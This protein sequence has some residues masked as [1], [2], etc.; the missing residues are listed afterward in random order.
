[1]P[2]IAALNVGIFPPEAAFASPGGPVRV[3]STAAHAIRAGRGP[4]HPAIRLAAAP[5]TERGSW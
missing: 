5:G 4:G 1:M 2:S 3:I